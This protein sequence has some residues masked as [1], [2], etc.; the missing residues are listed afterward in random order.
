MKVPRFVK[1]NRDGG[2]EL[3]RSGKFWKEEGE[4]EESDQ[5][6]IDSDEELNK[7]GLELS[8]VES[9]GEE[10]NTDDE[11]EDETTNPLMKDFEDPKLKK[12]QIR[13]EKWF[14]KVSILYNPIIQYISVFTFIY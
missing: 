5:S 7:E 14:D 6:S 1:Y 2:G 13:A 9:D 11:N 12:R 4:N 10:A 3:S 8:D